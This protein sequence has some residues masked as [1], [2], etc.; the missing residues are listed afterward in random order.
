[1][2]SASQLKNTNTETVKT[3][4]QT[5]ERVVH[6]SLREEVIPRLET[7]AGEMRQSVVEYV[8]SFQVNSGDLQMVKQCVE[9]MHDEVQ[10]MRLMIQNLQTDTTTCSPSE[11]R[12]SDVDDFIAEGK[13]NELI[14]QLGHSKDQQLV[15]YA[16]D[17]MVANEVDLMDGVEP[18][19][20]ITLAYLVG[21]VRSRD[22]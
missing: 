4:Q 22:E 5:V 6:S 17:Q 19:L 3:V 12:A 10:E 21:I 9:A 16:L 15:M 13:I 11:L 1:M 18:G 20:L 14:M 8:T 7:M 2:T